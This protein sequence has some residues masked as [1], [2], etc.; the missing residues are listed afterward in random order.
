MIYND[1]DAFFVSKIINKINQLKNLNIEFKCPVTFDAPANKITFTQAVV[2]K[3]L[4]SDN[5][6]LA[7]LH[8]Q[9]PGKTG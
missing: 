5:P 4:I 1:V 2:D 6:M 7:Q 3:R 9:L 8:D